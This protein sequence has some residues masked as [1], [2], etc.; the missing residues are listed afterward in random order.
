MLKRKQ[1]EF[2]VRVKTR[3]LHRGSSVAELARDIGRPRSTVSQAIHHGRFPR[4]RK[5]V[6]EALA[7]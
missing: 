1:V 7:V 2:A 3:L 5:Q 6:K 4:V